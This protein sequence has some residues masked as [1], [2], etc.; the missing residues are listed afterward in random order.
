MEPGTYVGFDYTLL[1]GGV[2]VLTFNSPERLNGLTQVIKREL[3][4]AVLQLEF[5]QAVRVIVFT[6]TGR[7]FCAGDDIT[8]RTYAPANARRLMP[9]LP[10]GGPAIERISSL[11]F[12]SAQ[13]NWMVANISKPTIAAINGVAIQSGLSLALSCDF[14]LASTDAR[15]GSATLRFGYQPDEGGHFLLVR[16]IGLA[17]ATEFLMRNRIVPADDALALGLVNE[18]VAPE[19]LQDRTLDLAREL[20]S[21]PQVAMRLLKRSLQNATSMSMEQAMEDIA[22]RTAVSDYHPDA[23]EGRASFVE[24]RSPRF[25]AWLEGSEPGPGA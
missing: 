12:R 11:K 5:D 4:E 20:A 14:R 21:G 3:A 6:G 7:A 9:D 2:A 17:R 25:N 13:L 15:L 10:A 18:V 24:R 8:G 16:L 22:V 19:Q 23:H 1:D